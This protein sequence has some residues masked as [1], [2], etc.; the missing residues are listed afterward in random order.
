MTKTQHNVKKEKIF[1]EFCKIRNLSRNS[2]KAY[3]VALNNYVKSQNTTLT[4]LLIEADKEE[5]QRIR[6]SKRKL[7]TRLINFKIYLQ[8][9]NYENQTINDYIHKVR[10]FYKT[11]DISLPYL[12]NNK[13]TTKE[14]YKDIIKKEDIKIAVEHAKNSKMRA[15]ILFMCSSGTAAQE[16]SNLTIQDFI[17]ATREYHNENNI[18][19]VIY[20]LKNRDDII[21]VFHI[22]RVKT[23]VPYFTFCSPEAT[24]YIL[25]YLQERL[26]KKGI[27][28]NESLFDMLPDS[29]QKNFAR[30][31]DNMGWGWKTSS[32]R[33]FHTHG[34]RKFFGTSMIE[35]GIS[36]LTVDFL[37]GRSIGKTRKA[38]YKMRP[39]KL[40]PVYARALNCLTV[41]EEVTYHDINTEE[42]EELLMYREKEKARDEKIRNLERLLQEYINMS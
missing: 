14:T 37:E 10:A 33:Y 40:K 6:H 26:L 36:E 13:V 9:N 2:E 16:T 29:I 31:N 22:V 32:C 23:G 30:L 42:K 20:S 15:I 17:D 12:P 41:F 24:K 39:E 7:R 27:S 21:P 5:E 18:T 38:Y 19:G 4:K 35:E 25:V 11:N 34:L 1:Q 8:K 3:K 28:N